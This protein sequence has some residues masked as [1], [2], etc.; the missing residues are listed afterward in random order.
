MTGPMGSAGRSARAPTSSPPLSAC[1]GS[2][3]PG[4]ELQSARALAERLLRLAQAQPDPLLLPAAHVALGVTLFHLGE[5]TAARRQVEQGLGAYDRHQQEAL[6]LQYGEDVGCSCLHYA[7]FALQVLGYPDQAL[8][9]GEEALALAEALSHPFTLARGLATTAYFYQ[10]RRE[11]RTAQARAESAI[12]LVA[13][14]GFSPV[15][16][17]H[18]T[19]V[20]GWALA[21]QGQAEAGVAHIRHALE[22]R[23]TLGVCLMRPY[24]LGF[25]AE[26][27]GKAGRAQE[28]LAVLREALATARRT[29][30]RWYDAELHRLQG[31]LTPQQSGSGAPK[32]RRKPKRVFSR[33]SRR[34]A[35]RGPSSSSCGR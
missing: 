26:A 6:V 14:H 30:E 28:G 5:P 17:A 22:V 18:G 23:Q 27:L 2:S 12:D 15:W 21:E 13:E 11:G 35:S 33:P 8:A 34:R 9:R 7:R 1:S 19:L 10:F 24:H 3:S 16:G 25:L 4:G 31:E 20:R 32:R 29:W